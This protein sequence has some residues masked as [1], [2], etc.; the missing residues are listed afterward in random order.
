MLE[1]EITQVDIIEG[2]IQVFARAWRDG[3]QIGFGKDGSVDIERFRIFNPPVL[4]P[5]EFGDI[6]VVAPPVIRD[7]A[8][9]IAE[10]A[11]RYRED[12]EE[13]LLQV[14]EHAI[15]QSGKDG[16]NIIIGKVGNT[17]STFYPDA[18][19]ESTSFDGW[20]ESDGTYRTWAATIALTTAGGNDS[21]TLLFNGGHFATTGDNFRYHTRAIILFDT[22]A[23]G[24]DTVDSAT[25]SVYGASKSDSSGVFNGITLAASSPASDTAIANGDFDS[26]GS[27]EFST[28]ISYASFST[29]GYNDFVLNGD[30]EAAVVNGISKFGTLGKDDFDDNK[31]V[32]TGTHDDYCRSHSAEN[33]SGTTQA[34]KLVVEHTAGSSFTPTPMMH[35]LAQTVA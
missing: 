25:L 34:P 21:H 1:I 22:S 33:S 32:V 4:V 27:T 11:F 30:G 13:A 28:S 10:I 35:M 31:P 9:D 26:F 16:S 12:P 24:T 14:V 29:S 7:E 2:G 20:F 6:V 3:T 17:S 18:D 23:I 19:T 15:E 8:P 5:D